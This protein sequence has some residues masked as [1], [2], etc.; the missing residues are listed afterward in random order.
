MASHY[1]AGKRLECG[2][3]GLVSISVVGEDGKESDE[4][5]T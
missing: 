4:T 5:S 1:L 2:V 3:A